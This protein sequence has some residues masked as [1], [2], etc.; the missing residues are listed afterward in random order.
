MQYR[1]YNVFYCEKCYKDILKKL[2][3][4]VEMSITVNSCNTFQHSTHLVSQV[5]Y[6]GLTGKLFPHKWKFTN[7]SRRELIKRIKASISNS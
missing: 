4:S 1:Q 2:E 7:D 3:D 5:Y 6:I